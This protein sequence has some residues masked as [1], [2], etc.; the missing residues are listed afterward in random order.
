MRS[1]IFIM[2]VFSC[3]K[4]D[5]EY[6]V[7]IAAMDADTKE[8][9]EKLT[10]VKAASDSS[11]FI[12]ACKEYWVQ[13][14]VALEINKRFEGSPGYVPSPIP[15]FFS[16]ESKDGRTITFPKEEAERMTFQTVNYYQTRVIPFI[17]TIIPMAK[18]PKKEPANIY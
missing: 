18:K 11:A 1:M 13:K 9:T 12:R 6:I 14:V 10:L 7:K 5:R 2:F 3:C 4:S 16:V 8:T 17:D 15:F